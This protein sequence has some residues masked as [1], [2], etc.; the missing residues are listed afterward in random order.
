MK[1]L[2]GAMIAL[3]SFAS[4]GCNQMVDYYSKVK[5]VCSYTLPPERRF[6]DYAVKTTLTPKCKA[7]LE[8]VIPYDADRDPSFANAPQGY[9]DKVTEAFQAIVAWPLRRSPENRILGF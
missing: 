2:I 3:T 9:K 7:A 4:L 6:G 5:D 1:F 8:G